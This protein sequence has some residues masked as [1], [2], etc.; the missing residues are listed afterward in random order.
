[1]QVSQLL[2]SAGASVRSGEPYAELWMGTH[3]K[4]P[5]LVA[6]EDGKGVSQSLADLLRSDPSLLG[7]RCAHAFDESLPF[8][9]KVLSVAQALSIQSHP[10][11]ALAARLHQQKPELYPDA[12]HKP[13]MVLAL[14]PFEALCG[15][16]E[17]ETLR[18]ILGPEPEGWP[19]IAE[20]SGR[21][22]VDA[23]LV[24]EGKDGQ[25]RALQ[26]V[27]QNLM[28]ADSERV[29]AAVERALRRTQD[30]SE[31]SDGKEDG[32]VSS[33]GSL[34]SRV[35]LM[36][37]L[38]RQYPGDVGVLCS[39]L[40]NYVRLSPGEAMFLAPNEPHAYVAGN[41]IECMACSDN[42]IRAGL[43]PK[44]RDT[45]ALCASLTYAM[46][47]PSVE[48]GEA[49]EACAGLRRYPSPFAEFE[50]WS[51]NLEAAASV[52][53]PPAQG[54][55]IGIVQAGRASGLGGKDGA[56]MELARGRVVF[57][58]AETSLEVESGSEGCQI[59]F[60]ACGGMG[61]AV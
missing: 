1:M 22:A 15:F 2:A 9:F 4:A 61:F 32:A 23:F 27:F 37:R 5:S 57:L 36:R 54:P 46:G 17:L 47:P 42:V 34:A 58:A 51:L 14:T 3:P 48:R 50:V 35:G 28:T 40:F 12:N 41:A 55:V 10:D 25:K 60:A 6:S 33:D 56:P 19:E 29:Q 44:A 38:Q 39:V 53:L 16:A 52:S 24:A 20:L 45:D 26:Q 30:V 49:V 7:S 59:F 21:V 43:T 13:E 8:L 11:K 31:G 18:R